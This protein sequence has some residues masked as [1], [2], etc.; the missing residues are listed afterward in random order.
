MLKLLIVFIR[1]LFEVSARSAASRWR[2][3]GFEF[4]RRKEFVS[5]EESFHTQTRFDILLV[6]FI[7]KNAIFI[8]P[9]LK[10]VTLLFSEPRAYMNELNIGWAI[11]KDLLT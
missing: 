6:S 1:N 11:I 3:T 7:T 8:T 5:S 2:R 9:L 10:T 4:R